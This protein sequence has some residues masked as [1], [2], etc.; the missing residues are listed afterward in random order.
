MEISGTHVSVKLEACPRVNG[1]IYLLLVCK[2]GS[3][4]IG[5]SLSLGYFLT[6]D[7]GKYFLQ[8]DVRYMECPA[9]V[10]KV[11][12]SFWIDFTAATQRIE[13]IMNR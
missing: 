4:P 3:L 2:M 10:L 8:R 11:E 1:G 12:E 9:I 5:E 13:V 6:K 7:Y